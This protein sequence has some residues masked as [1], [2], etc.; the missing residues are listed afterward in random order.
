MHRYEGNIPLEIA[1]NLA[2][3][4]QIDG[5]MVPYPWFV[6]MEYDIE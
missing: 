4:E 1:N 3:K 2:L 5:H 6:R